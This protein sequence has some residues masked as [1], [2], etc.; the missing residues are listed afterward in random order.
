MTLEQGTGIVHSSPA[1]GIDDFLSCRRYGMKDDDILNPV[2]GDGRFAGEPAV[3]RRPARSGT[4]IRASSTSCAKPARCSTRR[5]SRTA[6]CTAGGTR[7][8]SSIARRRNGSPAWTTCPGIAAPSRRSR[9]ATTALRGIEATQFFPAWGKARLYGMIANRPDWTLSRQRQWGMPLP[10]FV[11]R[12]T[13]ELHPDTLGAARARRGQGR[14]GRHRSV[15]RGDERGLRR[16]RDALSQAHRHARRLVRFRHDAPDGDGRA[17]RP[18]RPA[19]ARIRSRPD[20]RPTCISK[21]RTSIAAGSTRR[22]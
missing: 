22:C 12:E 16:R 20:F 14:S 19:R 8:R 17:G 21:A 7:R 10:F 13:D 6:T 1:Y 11:D 9:C 18:P 4:R 2:Q 5:S 3:L 15:V